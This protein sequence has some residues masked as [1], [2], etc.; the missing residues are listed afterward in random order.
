M[1]QRGCRQALHQFLPLQ[2]G[3]LWSLFC[4]AQPVQGLM[5]AGAVP[6]A[7]LVAG[8]EAWPALGM[9]CLEELFEVW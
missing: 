5:V 3:P 2:V 9:G 6:V 8:A 1:C 4:Q 7:A